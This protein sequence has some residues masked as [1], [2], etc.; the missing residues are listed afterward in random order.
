MIAPNDLCLIRVVSVSVFIIA[1]RAPKIIAVINISKCI[2]SESRYSVIALSFNKWRM[3]QYEIKMNKYNI[4]IQAAITN[5]H[6]L[7]IILDFLFIVN[8]KIT[9]KIKDNNSIYGF[10]ATSNY[11]NRKVYDF[12]F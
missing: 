10:K 6:C 9:L 12:Q 1:K 11:K 4:P 2:Y 3:P 5:S 7:K 8:H